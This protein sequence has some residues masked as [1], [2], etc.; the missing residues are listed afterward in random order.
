[1]KSIEISPLFRS[2]H[3]IQAELID[4]FE[5]PSWLRSEAADILSP[6]LWWWQMREAIVYSEEIKEGL[7]LILIYNIY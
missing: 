7:R 3:F 4:G 6:T 5:F 1:M 2:T